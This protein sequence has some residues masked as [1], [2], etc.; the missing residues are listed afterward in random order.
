MAYSLYDN[1]E[2]EVIDP[3]CSPCPQNFENGRVRGVAY[4]HE[5]YLATLLADPT[6]QSLWDAGVAASKIYIIPATTGT[7]DGGAPVEAPGFGNVETIITG[8]NFS[9]QYKDPAYKDNV[10]FYNTIK[11]SGH[12]YVAFR[13]A[14][15]TKISDAPVT[16]IPK[17]PVAD[18]KNSIVTWEVEVK[19][20]QP[21]H[22]VPFVT[23]V[24]L[25]SCPN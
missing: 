7:F 13:T 15:L 1:C 19:F 10:G 24:A 14:T 21:D 5:S 11:K 20:S 4:V 23:P 2:E 25:F 6:D 9:L 8:Y 3:V 22:S 16:V 17:A 18:D 12:Y